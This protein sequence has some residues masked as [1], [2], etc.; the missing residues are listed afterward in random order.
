MVDDNFVIV[1]VCRR[2]TSV[3]HPYLTTSGGLVYFSSRCMSVFVISIYQY[4][5][6]SLTQSVKQNY[7]R[8]K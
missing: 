4:I 7:T 3:R 6:H 2:L 5:T 1:F 8:S